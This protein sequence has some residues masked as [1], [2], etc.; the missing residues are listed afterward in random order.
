MKRV[1]HSPGLEPRVFL[2]WGPGSRHLYGAQAMGVCAHSLSK[3]LLRGAAGSWGASRAVQTAGGLGRRLGCAQ[4][5]KNATTDFSPSGCEDISV[6][7]K[8]SCLLPVWGAN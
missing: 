7:I 6:Q 8:G 3:I 4:A 2:M 1:S 5:S